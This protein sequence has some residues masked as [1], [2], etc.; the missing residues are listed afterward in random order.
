MSKFNCKFNSKIKYFLN[1]KTFNILGLFLPASAVIG[2]AFVTCAVPYVGV[3]MLT[4]D[5]VTTGCGYGA[6]FM[7][8]YNDLAY[9]DVAGSITG[10]SFGLANTFGTVPGIIAPYL[11]CFL[12]TYHLPS[13]WR[14]V[15][16]NTASV[17]V[18]GVIGYLILGSGELQPWASKKAAQQNP[19][20]GE[21]WRLI[22]RVHFPTTILFSQ[23]QNKHNNRS[24][25]QHKTNTDMN[26]I[27]NTTN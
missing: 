13:E 1:G 21:R 9:N 14:V 12:T 25:I 27:L 17:Y 15:F 16:F 18:A 5:L 26:S 22:T 7:G 11:V 24:E 3:A 4:F 8:N 2:L 19:E 23:K 10:F 6:G 20:E